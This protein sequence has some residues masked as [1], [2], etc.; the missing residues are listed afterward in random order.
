[1]SVSP[2][3]WYARMGGAWKVRL[4]DFYACLA[5]QLDKEKSNRLAKKKIKPTKT[6]E[7]ERVGSEKTVLAAHLALSTPLEYP[8]I[9]HCMHYN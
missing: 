8:S 6:T 4:F 9:C 7:R 5:K 1:M 3:F 2:F